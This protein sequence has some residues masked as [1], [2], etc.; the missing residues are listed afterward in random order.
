VRGRT[1]TTH[2]HDGDD[3]GAGPELEAAASLR[4]GGN[5]FDWFFLAMAHWRLGDG[6]AARRSFDRAVQW[7]VKHEPHDDEL[8]CFRAEAEAL[9]AETRRR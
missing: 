8:R 9:P 1:A 7:M 4:A 5:S 3:R 6:D 2:R